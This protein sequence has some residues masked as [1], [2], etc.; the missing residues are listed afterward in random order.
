MEKLKFKYLDG[1]FGM[2]WFF[3]IL[4]ISGFVIV[5][6]KLILQLQSW[7]N[8]PTYFRGVLPATLLK[9]RPWHM[10]F[11]VKNTFFKNTFFPVAASDILL[12]LL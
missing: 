7:R 6:I 3:G 8:M 4:K 12:N 9:K 2:F 5:E 10:C 1:V 11:P